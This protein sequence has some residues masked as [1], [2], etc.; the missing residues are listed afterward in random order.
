ML[1]SNS[2]STIISYHAGSEYRVTTAQALHRRLNA[3]GH[4]VYWN[5]IFANNEDPTFVFL[6]LLW[7]ALYAWDETL[8][9]LYLHICSLVRSS[10]DFVNHMFSSTNRNPVSFTQMTFTSLKSCMSYKHISCTTPH[11]LKNSERPLYSSLT[12][13]TQHWMTSHDIHQRQG[14]ARNS[15]CIMSART[16]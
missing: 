7:Y 6:V 13:I 1:R 4:S 15:S 2:N 16:S 9:A 12:R 14:Y 3:A 8:E 10:L 11:S 5:N